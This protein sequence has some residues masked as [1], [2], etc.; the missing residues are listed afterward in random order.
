MYAELDI[1]AAV[2]LRMVVVMSV[3]KT[4]F[5]VSYMAIMQRQISFKEAALC[6]FQAH[7][8]LIL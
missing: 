2:L 6:I 8:Y 5:M 4:N 1:Q 3:L 7:N